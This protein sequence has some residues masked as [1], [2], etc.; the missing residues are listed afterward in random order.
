MKS[1]L[2]LKD[3][4]TR[5]DQ[6]DEVL[7]DVSSQL[8]QLNGLLEA[9]QLEWNELS[10]NLN[11]KVV[12]DAKKKIEYL[13]SFDE[14]KQAA[15]LKIEFNSSQK[16]KEEIFSQVNHAVYHQMQCE[17]GITSGS[18]ADSLEHYKEL[19]KTVRKDSPELEFVTAYQLSQKKI[20]G[21][22]S[23][24]QIRHD[25][26]ADI[27]ACLPMAKIEADLGIQSTYFLL[28]TA[29]YYGEWNVDNNKAIFHRYESLADYYLELQA[30]GHEVAIHT[31]PLHLYQNIKVDGAETLVAEL[32]WLRSIGIKVYG[33]APHN[34]PLEYGA[35]NSA[36]FNGR[37][38]LTKGGVVHG[39]IKNG[40]WA[41]LGLLEEKELGL[42]YET[43]DIY[44]SQ[45]KCEVTYVS[46]IS[47]GRWWKCSQKA[48]SLS[49]NKI[50]KPWKFWLINEGEDMPVGVFVN[51]CSTSGVFSHITNAQKSVSILSVHPEHFGYRANES[52]FPSALTK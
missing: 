14:E 32:E 3:M 24:C 46:I 22:T 12:V 5:V 25:V 18:I 41:G 16:T 11:K 21:Q 23:Y 28:H 50:S 1:K 13:D 2:K 26:D 43:D 48:N 19:L 42:L 52:A 47:P 30:L 33:T 8:Q 40:L 45:I 15:L 10:A 6:V 17:K 44:D 20:D 37:N 39:V 34:N 27:V 38:K 7:L 36:I 9:T 29:A 35:S 51:W 4:L 49:N 31:D